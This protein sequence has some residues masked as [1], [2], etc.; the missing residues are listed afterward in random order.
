MLFFFNLP[1]RYNIIIKKHWSL[2]NGRRCGRRINSL[3]EL[4]KKARYRKIATHPYKIEAEMDTN[5]LKTHHKPK[6]T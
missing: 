6:T 5:N 1:L 3:Q 4:T 2:R